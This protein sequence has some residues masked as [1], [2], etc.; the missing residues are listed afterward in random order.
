M[1]RVLAIIL[2][3][4][5]TFTIGGCAARPSTP[6]NLVS[7]EETILSREEEEPIISQGEF[8]D[9]NNMD[10]L[11]EEP[12]EEESTPSN[13]P[14]ASSSAAS[15]P[16]PPPSEAASKPSSSEESGDANISA[17]SDEVRAIWISYLD[18]SPMIKGKSKAGFRSSIG[19]AFDNCA[20]LG[21][22]TVMVQVRPFADALYPSN[23]F[24]FSYIVNSSNIEGKDPGYD[25]LEIMVAEAHARGLKFEAWLNPY[26]IR[27]SGS[28]VG[29]SKDN[30]AAQWRDDGSD[31]V[32]EF[33]G[34]LYYN[35]ARTEVQDLIVDGVKEIVENYQV[36]GIHFDD[37]F[38]PSP[39]KN[40][41]SEAYGEYKDGGGSQSLGDWRRAN[42]DT[43]VKRVYKEIKAIRSSCK[44]GISPQGNHG[45]NYNQQYINVEKWAANT[46]YVDYICPQ[47]YWGY[48][49]NSAPYLKTLESWEEMFTTSKVKLYVGLATYKIGGSESDFTNSTDMMMRQVQ[50]AREQGHY[51]GFALYR[52]D[53]LFNPASGLETQISKEIENLK[54]ILN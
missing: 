49:N 19:E 16:A 50:D 18:I 15:K 37:Y 13:A 53:S 12:S 9:A 32:L 25:P 6:E 43:L 8:P 3:A 46:G 11:G 20:D 22:N 52:Y 30:I 10:A 31:Y 38:Y 39:D 5:L 17:S 23:Y 21:V 1:K 29:L 45:N 26:R 24:P 47:I 40:F 51:K 28:K 14:A 41:D 2:A 42:V 35:P 33:S 48:K 27:T 4:A 44:F 54:S 7:S 36:D 34:G